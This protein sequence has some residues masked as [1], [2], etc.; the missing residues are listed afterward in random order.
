MTKYL[1]THRYVD[2]NHNIFFTIVWLKPWNC[3]ELTTFQYAMN[4]AGKYRKATFSW[5]I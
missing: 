4:C 5:G 3:H 1:Y 2:K